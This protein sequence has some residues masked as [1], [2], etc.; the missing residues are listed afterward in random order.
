M[1]VPIPVLPMW[2]CE[3]WQS[4][5]TVLPPM[6]TVLPMWECELWKSRLADTVP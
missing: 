5:Q 4:R 1:G 6:E 2:G 3:L